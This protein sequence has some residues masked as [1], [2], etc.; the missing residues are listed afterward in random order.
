M[1]EE[2]KEEIIGEESSETP[3][4]VDISD[5]S[6][7]QPDWAKNA[8]PEEIRGRAPEGATVWILRLKKEW[9]H[10]P[11][12]GDRIVVL[13]ALSDAEENRAAERAS[14]MGAYRLYRECAKAMIRAIDGSKA[15]WSASGKNNDVRKFWN[16]IGPK[17]REL[18]T[19]TYMRAHKFSETEL[20]DFF[21]NCHVVATA[22]HG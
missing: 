4:V 2:V 19:N 18:I 7:K 5:E 20:A 3:D 1:S 17:C 13:W 9:T 15:D 22:L 16:D 11:S 12:A 10:R 21:S 8:I 14:S 6:A